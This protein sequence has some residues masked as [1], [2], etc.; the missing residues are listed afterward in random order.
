MTPKEEICKKFQYCVDHPSIICRTTSLSI[1]PL[2]FNIIAP[3]YTFNSTP[4]Y[5]LYFG[6]VQRRFFQLS[7]SV[8]N[9][10]PLLFILFYRNENS[11]GHGIFKLN[12]YMRTLN[13]IMLL[14]SRRKN[15]QKRNEKLSII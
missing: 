2:I 4:L 9:G 12:K 3:I 7:F 5:A 14:K 15:K 11:T 8:K 1:H 10:Y 6:P 13:M